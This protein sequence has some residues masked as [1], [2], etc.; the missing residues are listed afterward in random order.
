MP[1]EYSH[2]IG[3]VK[4]VGMAL[5]V[6]NATHLRAHIARFMLRPLG[7]YA[8]KSALLYVFYNARKF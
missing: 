3:G 4:G 1:Q 5:R 6:E 7:V 8:H 2:S